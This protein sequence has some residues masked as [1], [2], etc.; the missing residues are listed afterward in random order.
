M[1]AQDDDLNTEL[2]MFFSA[3]K[4]QMPRSSEK[5]AKLYSFGC[6]TRPAV[7]D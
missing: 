1:A 7:F 5:S 2:E 3:A 6:G 4:W